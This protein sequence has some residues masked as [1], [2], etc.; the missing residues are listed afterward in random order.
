M[1]ATHEEIGNQFPRDLISVQQG[2]YHYFYIGNKEKLLEIA[3]KVLPS[4]PQ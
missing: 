1:I 3:R 4:N 2:Q